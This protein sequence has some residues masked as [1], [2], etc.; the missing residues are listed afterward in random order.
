LADRDRL[1]FIINALT[2]MRFC[3]AD[4]QIDI[5]IKGPP[6]QG[7]DRFRP[8]FMHEKRA[9][10]HVRVIFGHWSALGYFN[11]EGVVALDTGCV[12]G[13]GLTAFNLDAN[14]PPVRVECTRE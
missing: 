12:W 8:W 7:K 10:R 14:E 9:S 6:E 5:H 11:G 4:G 13:G 1:R 2:R 3:T